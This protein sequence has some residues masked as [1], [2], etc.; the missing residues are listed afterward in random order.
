MGGKSV[1][2][3]EA[4]VKKLEVALATRQSSD[5]LSLPVPMRSPDTVLRRQ[6]DEGISTRKPGWMQFM[7]KRPHHVAIWNSLRG[8][9]PGK[10]CWNMAEAGKTPLITANEL[11]DMG[12]SI[13]AYPSILLLRVITVIREGLQVI[14]EQ[15]FD[16]G[17][18]LTFSEFTQLFGAEKW[19]KLEDQLW[20]GEVMMN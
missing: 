19:N 16:Q 2:A 15:N 8:N 1:V 3:A 6:S 12:Y 20:A 18:P 7:L 13:I 14:T 4:A 17:P 10:P 5:F 11:A 9:Y